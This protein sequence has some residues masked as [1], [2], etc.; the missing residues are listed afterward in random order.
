MWIKISCHILKDK[1]L[2]V[3]K[4][5]CIPLCSQLNIRARLQLCCLQL[6]EVDVLCYSCSFFGTNMGHYIFIQDIYLE[7]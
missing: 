2:G 1:K 7:C 5:A 4:T 3:L 6:G